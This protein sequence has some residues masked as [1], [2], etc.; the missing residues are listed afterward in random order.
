[1]RTQAFFNSIG[2]GGQDLIRAKEKAKTQEQKVLTFFKANPGK[3]FTPFTVHDFIF[4]DQTPWTSTRRCITNLTRKKMLT[5]CTN[6]QE[7]ERYGKPNYVWCYF[8]EVN[9]RP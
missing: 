3:Y 7:I 9:D 1:M 8:P 4:S 2:L 6:V 5:K